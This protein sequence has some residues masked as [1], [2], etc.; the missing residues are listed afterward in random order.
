VEKIIHGERIGKLG[1]IALGCCAVIFD[2]SGQKI[3]LTRR[4]DN[5]RWC[6]PGGHMQPGESAAETC[7]RKVKMETGLDVRVVRLVGVYSSP[8][9]LLEYADGNRFHLVS[10]SFEAEALGGALAL[11]DETTACDY[12]SQAEAAQL[13]VMDH[14]LERLEDAFA[15]GLE[16]HVR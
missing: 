10:L 5:G 14:H 3:L 15:T 16:T 13:D 8:H 9:R 2:P 4:A 1:R 6:L 12:F 11:S 7:I